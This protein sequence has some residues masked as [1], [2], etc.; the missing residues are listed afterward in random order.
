MNPSVIGTEDALQIR[1]VHLPVSPEI[2]PPAPGW[3]LLAVTV[4]V[5]LLWI[6][7]RLLRLWRRRRLQKEILASLDKLQREYS[8]EQIPHFLAEVSILLR[9]VA[10]MKF[11]RQQVAALTGKG[12]LSFLDQHGGDGEY[13]NGVGSVLAA[14][15][16]AR[17]CEVDKNA[18][19]LLT[20]KWIKRNTR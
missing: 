15:P 4:L 5:L 9:R 19:L 17:H 12:W 14:G 20:R 16:Y 11:P 7:I 3:W 1:D 6:T 18:L 2:W 8:D 10:L 13:S